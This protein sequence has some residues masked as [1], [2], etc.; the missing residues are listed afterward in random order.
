MNK[1][2]GIIT[3]TGAVNSGKTSFALQCGYKL[4]EIEYYGFDG[5]KPD[6]YAEDGRKL[7]NAFGFYREYLGIMAE[8][9][10]LKMIEDF[11]ADINTKRPNTKVCIIDGEEMFRRNFA[12]YVKR[13]KDKLRDYWYGRGGIWQ[14]Y[15]ELGF[16][17]KFE[18]ALFTSLQD[19][20]DLIFII[21]H[22]EGVRDDESEK[23]EKP[24]IPGKHRADIKEPLIQKA[25]VRFW[26]VP[27]DGSLCPSAIVL[28]NPGKHVVDTKTGKIKT[29]TVFPPKLSPFALGE[30]RGFVSLW[31]VIEHYE[32]NPFSEKFPKVE[33]FEMLTDAEQEMVSEDLTESDKQLL[34]ELALL[35]AKEN[36]QRVYA[37]V[38]LLL[39]V[40]DKLPSQIIVAKLKAGFPDM[41]VTPQI[42]DEVLTEI[43]LA[44]G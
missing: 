9:K 31:D 6:V 34:G 36:H 39:K 32:K 23:D 25:K 8:S 29:M 4:Q 12:A 20:F 22:L 17:K 24:L 2:S 5:K 44:K 38:E 3:V 28:K 33:K 7:E 35:A 30:K 14:S 41:V 16:A 18:A 15:E 40:N 42:V 19:R 37:Q 13:N 1:L 11:L 10:E 27:T 43:K 26:I 21:N